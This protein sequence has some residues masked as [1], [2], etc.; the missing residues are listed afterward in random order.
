MAQREWVPVYTSILT[1]EKYLD[2]SLRERGAW[3]HVLLL[4]AVAKPEGQFRR[5]A[6]ARLLDRERDH[7][8][9]YPDGNAM[10]AALVSVG[11]LDEEGE[12]VS[13]HD[14]DHWQKAMRG[15]SDDP[16]V[17]R[18]RE[19]A[20]YWRAQAEEARSGSSLPDSAEPAEPVTSLREPV[21]EEKRGEEG[22]E[23]GGEGSGP[24]AY[25]WEGDDLDPYM[26]ACQ[27]LGFVPQSPD[28]A[29]EWDALAKTFGAEAVIEVIGRTKPTRKPWDLKKE[30]EMILVAE[31]RKASRSAQ[32]QAQRPA[33]APEEIAEIME[34]NRASAREA[35]KKLLLAGTV[36]PIRPGDEDLLREA[37]EE[38]DGAG[39]G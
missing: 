39:R 33:Q 38:A 32:R 24:G 9:A 30:A 19:Q 20:R 6:L 26:V 34:R 29:G 27:R 11:L 4:G 28:F 22:E 8:E 31:R 35:R 12:V 17:K 36:A 3:L 15:P 21:I 2:L 18:L 13:I 10:V 37:K 1:S 7:D 16:E 5:T 14:R 25:P 23:T